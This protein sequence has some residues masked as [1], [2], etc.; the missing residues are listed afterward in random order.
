MMEVIRLL[1]FDTFFGCKRPVEQVLGDTSGLKNLFQKIFL[2]FG[3]FSY[4]IATTDPSSDIDDDDGTSS[5]ELKLAFAA[6]KAGECI[7]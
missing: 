2:R 4:S 7:E 6:F 5:K 3:G 1:I